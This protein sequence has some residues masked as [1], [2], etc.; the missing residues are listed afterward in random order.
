MSEIFTQCKER[1][2][3]WTEGWNAAHEGIYY[4]MRLYNLGV[5]DPLLRT[6]YAAGYDI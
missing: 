5:W 2:G 6:N 3:I 1:R 4:Q